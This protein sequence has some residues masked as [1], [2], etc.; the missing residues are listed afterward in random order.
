[1]RGVGKR[2]LL[3]GLRQALVRLGRGPVFVGSAAGQHRPYAALADALREAL[4][5]LDTMGLGP[6]VRAR[7]QGALA[8]LD[9]S[10]LMA[11]DAAPAVAS[12]LAFHE[13]SLALVR[14]VQTQ[15]GATIILDE[16]QSS[17]EDTRA[18]CR[19]LGLHVHDER[20]RVGGA[21][22][23]SVSEEDHVG[24]LVADLSAAGHVHV[25]RV[26][27]LDREGLLRFLR[28]SSAMDRLLTASGG[29]PEDIDELLG[30]V[31]LDV[32]ALLT[33][34]LEKLGTL[35]RAVAEALAVAA[36]PVG[37]D[38]LSAMTGQPA[39]SLAP[40]LH[41]MVTDGMVT[42]RAAN[43][44]LLFSLSRSAHAQRLLGLLSSDGQAR[45]HQAFGEHLELKGTAMLE[46]GDQLLA[47][48]FL[49]GRD[50]L[51]GVTYALSASE[52]LTVTHAYGAA[53][54]LLLQA[55]PL[56][57]RPEERRA[58]LARLSE[59][60]ELRGDL[61]AALTDAGRYK[62]TLPRAERAN[63]YRR[64]GE[65]LAA[66]GR[67]ALAVRAL[68]RA[69]DLLA[70]RPEGI[71][72]QGLTLAALAEALYVSGD[73]AQSQ[74]R[75]EAALELKDLPETVRIRLGNT[76][77]KLALAREDWTVAS[78]RFHDNRHRAE[79]L[80]LTAEVARAEINLGVMNFRRGQ[81]AEAEL[82]L[83][84]ALKLAEETSDLPNQAF[85]VLN[86]GSLKHQQRDLAAAL[87]LHHESLALF[88]KIGNRAEVV[89]AS[90]N[91]A[92]LSLVLGDLAGAEEHLRRAQTMIDQS[93]LRTQAAYLCALEA[94]L[95]MARG[96]PDKALLGYGEARARYLENGQRGRAAEQ[97]LR[98]A[99]AAL[100]AR[101]ISSAEEALSHLTACRTD[102]DHPRLRSEAALAQARVL[103]SGGLAAADALQ[104]VQNLVD[105]ARELVSNPA[106]PEALAMV[107]WVEA[108]LW[109]ARGDTRRSD[110]LLGAA[111]DQLHK[112]AAELPPALRDGY[113]R[114]RVAVLGPATST[115]RTEPRGGAPTVAVV[116]NTP[117][118]PASDVVGGRSEL[119]NDRY[120]AMVGSSPS[121][122]RVFAR[123]DRL[124]GSTNTVLIRGESGTGKELVANAIHALSP[125]A[126][127]PFIK[128]NCAALVETLL[129]SELF[130]HEK[131][132]FTG[133]HARKVGRFELA[134]GGTI[135]LDEIGDISPKTQVSLLRVLQERVFERVGGST[136]LK[137]DCRVICATNRNLE[138]M[139]KAG[140]FREDLYY[141][142]KG[143][144]VELPSLRERRAD[145][146]ALVQHVVRNASTELG[147]QPPEVTAPAMEA[148]AR[149]D[150]PGNIRELENTVRSLVLFADGDAIGTE[151]LKEFREFTAKPRASAPQNTLPAPAAVA[152]A[153]S[154]GG[155]P[156]GALKKQIEFEAIARA[157]E[158]TEGN[159]T[160]A[161]DLLQMKRP[162]LSQIV[163][164]NPALRAV[165]D[166]YRATEGGAP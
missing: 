60:H 44:A 152:E 28:N 151:H 87:R 155:V 42:R 57:T 95:A 115:A 147:R 55:L 141:R 79:S 49:A 99:Q 94:D 92:N 80:R 31:P 136:P 96:E 134:R 103:I 11:P 146:P 85:C 47:R 153:V 140:T 66:S 165:K 162:R 102:L 86:L 69:L 52:R 27:G 142:L 74:A 3:S 21:L 130:G 157:L 123:L 112:V 158:E 137:V 91:V 30:A 10:Q 114:S 14:D 105:E 107:A 62:G 51:R 126:G 143:V 26:G 164:G 45:L 145:V 76:L 98:S 71:A 139:V 133:A 59:L 101:Q 72:E 43:G 70:E 97:W 4:S 89:R 23:L 125:K 32:G 159:I 132:A 118:E 13:A 25:V 34:R 108:E 41:A 113:V 46:G 6:Q 19:Y 64:L 78:A 16:L 53:T 121:L 75:A 120:R 37:V 131:G 7:H 135:F 50:A 38:A 128:V 154:Q 88:A 17:D 39:L 54:D 33:G 148:L 122:L 84:R 119:W 83:G 161:A 138:A 36:T 150:W 1:P 104:R 67:P 116:E 20:S 127:G 100:K 24:T 109:G 117:A 12:R 29:R 58:I 93:G 48:H 90:L 111:R 149:Y 61:M 163:N 8:V 9:P 5:H 77:G 81:Y 73:H 65:L 166:R 106:D 160:R 156:L 40:V 22:V 56:A 82:H 144:V 2:Q 63:A 18:L 15:T 35:A 110:K 68:H 124:Q 129:L